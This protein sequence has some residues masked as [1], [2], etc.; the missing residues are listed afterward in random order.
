MNKTGNIFKLAELQLRREGREPAGDL[1][2][3]YAIKIRRWLDKHKGIADKIMA[4]GKVYQ[5]KNRFVIA[6]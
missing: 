3:D 1:L 6:K 5:Y 4:G 2:V